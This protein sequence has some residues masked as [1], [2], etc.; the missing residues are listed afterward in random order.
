[1]TEQQAKII[2][3]SMEAS[4]EIAMKATSDVNELRQE[5]VSLRHEIRELKER[6]R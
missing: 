2:Q 1:M 5:I 4:M 6:W 3:S